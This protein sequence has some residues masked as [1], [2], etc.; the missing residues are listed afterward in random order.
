MFNALPKTEKTPSTNTTSC[1]RAR[2]AL[3]PY[4]QGLGTSRKAYQM[5]PNMNTDAAATAKIALRTVSPAMMGETDSKSTLER[6]SPR[7]SSRWR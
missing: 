7:V 3:T 2:M 1:T 6:W 5:Y 4:R